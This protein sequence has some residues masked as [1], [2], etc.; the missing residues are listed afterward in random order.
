MMDSI[1]CSGGSGI[2]ACPRAG[3]N[4]FSANGGGPCRFRY[5]Y[6][7]G[8]GADTGAAV[9]T[10]GQCNVSA[11][12]L[13]TGSSTNSRVRVWI[14]SLA[15]HDGFELDDAG[16]I[17]A[18]RLGGCG[19]CPVNL[20]P[21]NLN[22]NRGVYRVYEGEIAACIA[23]GATAQLFWKFNYKSPAQEHLRPDTY[24]YTAKFMGGNCAD[25]EQTFDNPQWVSSSSV[26]GQEG[27]VEEIPEEIDE[28]IP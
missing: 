3:D 27:E 25:M 15:A 13:D 23:N 28:E 8:T 14:R 5:T 17:L 16:H 22:R 6:H 9:V 10:S 21:Q 12:D 19:D 18:S 20:F 7:A 24:T 2:T 1:H 4:H 26:Q 11:A